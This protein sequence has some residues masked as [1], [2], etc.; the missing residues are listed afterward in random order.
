MLELKKRRL[1][2][3]VEWGKEDGEEDCEETDQSNLDDRIVKLHQPANNLDDKEDELHQIFDC[4]SAFSTSEAFCSKEAFITWAKEVGKENGFVVIIKASEPGGAGKKPRLR[5]ACERS[6]NYRQS[7]YKP[8]GQMHRKSTGTKKCGCPFEIHGV[9]LAKDDEWG[10]KVVFGS[11]N[12]LP[13]AQLEGHSFAGRLSEK[14]KTMVFDMSKSMAKPK[15]ILETLKQLDEKNMT[16]MKT[17]YNARQ[18][19]KLI[20]EA[21]RTQI[22]QLMKQL[23]EC[24][25]VEWH[26]SNESTGCVRD[27]F[28]AHPA[29][30]EL[31]HAFPSV[32]IMDGTSKNNRYRLPLLEIVGVTSIDLT[33]SVAFVYI[34]VELED[35]YIWAMEKLRSLMSFDRLPSVVVTACDLELMNAIRKVFPNTTNLLCRWHISKA[36]LD[37]C[38]KF[39]ERKEKWEAFMS[40]WSVLVFSSDEYEYQRHLSILETD[41]HTYPRALK[42][43]RDAWLSRYKESFVAAWTNKIMHFGNVTTNRAEGAHAKLKKHLG[44]SQGDFDTSWN[45]II[46]LIE[47]QHVEI[48]ASFRKS[49]ILVEHNLNQTLFKDLNG[50]VS[51]SA[52]D[53]ILKEAERANQVGI[54]KLPCGC[55]IRGTH[56]LPCAHEIAEFIKE[57]RP[58][59]LS[60]VHPHWTKLDLM[61]GKVNEVCSELTIVPELEAIFRRFT[62]C[63][64]AGKLALKRRLR[65]LGDPTMFHI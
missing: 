28:W 13:T 20:E 10:V 25:Y 2:M 15:D 42:Y 34:E 45:I 6:G 4:T 40:T 29:G 23:D 11:H 49:L 5:L 3:D 18:R 39:F 57:G 50:L 53:M 12:H 19:Y 14:E 51:R 38:K 24:K 59:P 47:L 8:K 33:F 63:D 17:I 54:D 16:T 56:G 36:V 26:R 62:A 32:L 52:F 7:K 61:K 41:Y 37:N 1:D 64:E 21:G 22:Q 9:K 48:K 43:V 65:E 27:L 60:V 46:S 58:I 44:C 31:L 55:V 35:N 30:I